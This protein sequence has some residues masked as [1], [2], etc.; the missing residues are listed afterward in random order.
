MLLQ[1][2]RLTTSFPSATGTVRAVDDVSFGIDRGEV[3]A[4]VGESGSGKSVTALSATR[5]VPQP[6]AVIEGGAAYLDGVDMLKLSLPKMRQVLGKRVSMLFQNAFAALHP[7]IRIGDQL[8]EVVK[9]HHGLSGYDARSKAAQLIGSV[10]FPEPETVMR[11][12]AF[13]ITAGDAQ[14]VMLA[15]AL[16]GDPDLLIADEPTSLLDA[17][18]QDEILTLIK[19]IQSRTG[20]A[21]WLITH[22]FGVVSR[23]ADRVVVMYAGKAVEVGPAGAVLDTPEHPYSQGLIAS[24]PETGTKERLRQ[25]PGEIPDL[26]ALP[27]GCAFRPRCDKVFAECARVVPPMVSTDTGRAARC[28]LY[29][30]A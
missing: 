16:S 29:A 28:L 3:V 13:E 14:R 17:V 7:L 23:M 30:A 5:L 18:A 6:P 20:M 12:Y 26:T 19:D 25:I 8:V 21:V 2:D 22:D 27:S 4:V 1:I 9:L 10:G 15:I 11:R 24:V